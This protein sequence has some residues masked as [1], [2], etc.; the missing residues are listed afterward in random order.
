MSTFLLAKFFVKNRRDGARM[1]ST[2][3][4]ILAIASTQ[5]DHS[6]GQ[7]LSAFSALICIYWWLAY[8]RLER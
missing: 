2:G 6:W 1:L 3:L 7:A 4:L 8:R 5:I